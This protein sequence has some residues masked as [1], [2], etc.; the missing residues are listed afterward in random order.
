MNHGFGF[1]ESGGIRHPETSSY[2]IL[3][4]VREA[5][6]FPSYIGALISRR[7]EVSGLFEPSLALKPFSHWEGFLKGR[8]VGR[9]VC[10]GEKGRE[11]VAAPGGGKN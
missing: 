5:G 10:V 4:T 9:W 3:T 7:V 1:T 11:T 8:F 6:S 2:P